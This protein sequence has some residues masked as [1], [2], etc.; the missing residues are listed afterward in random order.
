M[1]GRRSYLS[2][3]FF[4][5]SHLFFGVV[6][7][8]SKPTCVYS[9]MAWRCLF[10]AGFS[11]LLVASLLTH[12]NSEHYHCHEE[13]NFNIRCQIDGCTKEYSKVNSFTEHVRAVHSYP[14]QV[15]T[16]LEENLFCLKVCIPNYLINATL[17]LIYSITEND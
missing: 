14:A 5:R 10:C 4:P 12:Y 8:G 16:T 13:R 2:L 1:V 7:N 9:E 11:A 6:C 3:I 17:A 15:R